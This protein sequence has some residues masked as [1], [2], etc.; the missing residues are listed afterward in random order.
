[1]FVL[2]GSLSWRSIYAVTVNGSKLFQSLKNLKEKCEI[3]DVLLSFE[4]NFLVINVIESWNAGE[5]GLILLV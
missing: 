4:P 3:S 1:M 5:N 2:D